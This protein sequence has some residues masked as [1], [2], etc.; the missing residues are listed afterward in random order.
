[1]V[2]FFRVQRITEWNTI[3]KYLHYSVTSPCI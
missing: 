1:M 3:Y 2:H